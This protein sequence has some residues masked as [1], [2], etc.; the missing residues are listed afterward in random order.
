MLVPALVILGSFA[1]VAAAEAQ[2]GPATVD[3]VP[4][5]AHRFAVTLLSSF[6][7]IPDK[8]LPKDVPE[9]VYRTQATLFG[10][11][12]YFVRV[13]FFAT[14]GEAE[15]AKTRL[16]ARYPAAYVTEITPEEYA[17]AAGG[18]R[19]VMPAPAKATTP[20]P[21]V[22]EELYTI[23]LATGGTRLPTP[24]APLPDSLRDQVLYS[25]ELK[26]NGEKRATLNLGFFTTAAEAEKARQQLLK[27]YPKAQ[28]RSA[29]AT[30]RDAAADHLVSVPVPPPAAKTAVPGPVLPPAP[31]SPAITSPPVMSAAPPSPP[32]ATPAAPTT[33]TAVEEAA[34]PKVIASADIE[35]KA[36][37][38]MD[39][40]KSALTRGDNQT[41]LSLL[42]D[43]LRLPPNS[44]SQEAQELVG[45]AYE[46][47]GDAAG[48]TREYRLYMKLYPEGAGTDRVRQRLANLEVLQAAPALKAATGKA[49]TS[50]TT[51]GSF[52]Q[53][54]YHG[55]SRIDTSTLVGPSLGQSTF[56]AVDQSTLITDLTLSSRY[57][58]ADYD[59]RVVIRENNQL[60]FLPDQDNRNRLYAAYYELRN[61]LYDYSGRIGRQ[62][63]DSGGV[64]GPFDGFAAG[65][66]F[67]PKWRLNVVAGI[68]VQFYPINSDKRFWG[69]NLDFGTFAEHWNGNAY[70]IKQTVDGILDREAVGGELRYFHPRGSMI[71]MTDYDVAY[72]ELNI[73]MVQGTWQTGTSTTWNMLADHRKSPV[74]TTSNA[75]IGELDTSI[76][77]QL[78]TQTEDQ[79]RAAAVAKTPTADLF[80]LGVAHNFTPRWQLGG[81]IKLYNI[82]GTD[83]SGSLPATEGTGNTLVYTLQGIASGL[84]TKHDINVLNLSYLDNQSYSG[85][86]ASITNRTIFQDRWTTDLALRFYAQQDDNGMDLTRWYPSIRIGYT[87]RKQITLEA[88]I[89][90]EKTRTSTPTDTQ[91]ITRNYYSLGYRWNF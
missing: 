44:Q 41:A 72:H 91:D 10:R 49:P 40:V 36:K 67:L 17:A 12:I 8:L 51:Y 54:Y 84:L 56:S 26:V 29:T 1:V 20:A 85:E 48:A 15:A 47:I 78:T 38:Q 80:M 88:E 64:L 70:F 33:P 14:G 19:Q 75:V 18:A 16:L 58:S 71:A 57:R 31:I 6:D 34:A 61:K 83:A 55:N 11:T 30:E 45:L 2:A 28:V 74:L 4:A 81:D 27:S 68:P 73:F 66:S 59:S 24:A 69:T 46:R 9:R 13:G 23:T 60:N 79:L 53:Y 76:A 22:P 39:Q 43:L 89:A 7:P 82:S 77:S 63:G 62:P 52:A 25:R 3:S 35:A 65:Y 5:P 42:N 32:S 87:W 90:I 21:I 37:A 50:L 86:S